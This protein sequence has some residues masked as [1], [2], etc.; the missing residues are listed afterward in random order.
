MPRTIIKKDISKKISF[1]LKYQTTY[2][3]SIWIYGNHPLLGGGEKNN[4]IPLVYL[5]ETYWVI[6]LEF[7]KSDNIEKIIYHYLIKDDQ[8]REIVE[9]GDDKTIDLVSISNDELVL[10]DTWNYAGQIENVFYTEPFTSTL[11]NEKVASASA[12]K[13]TK[14]KTHLFKVKAPLIKKGQSLCIIGESA[15]LGNWDTQ[16]TLPLTKIKETDYFE[17]ALDLKQTAFPLIYKYGIYDTKKKA[18]ISYELGNNRVLYEPA[19]KNKL[20][21]CND[22]FAALNN[23]QWKGAGVAIPVFSLRSNNSCG[24]GEF[25]DIKLL[26]DWSKKI[27]LK[28]IQLLPVNDTTATHSWMDSYPYAAISAFALHPL[29]I[30]IDEMILPKQ[31]NLI[32]SFLIEKEKLNALEVVDYEAVMKLKWKVL[33]TLFDKNGKHEL[34]ATSF[35]EFFNNNAHWLVPYSAFSYLRELHGTIDYNM[36][37]TH[38]KFD[39]KAIQK[40]VDPR[41]T[42]YTEIS[43]YYYVQFHLHLQLKSATSYAHENGIIVKGDIPIGVYR[44][45]AD[46]WQHP[47]LFHMDKQAGAPP[48]D[49]AVKGQNW[50]FPTY[51][52]KNMA[53]T[54]YSWWKLRFEQMRFYFDAFRIDHILGF[55]RIWSIPMHAVDGIMGRF[56]PAIPLNIQDFN[57]KGISWDVDRYTKPFINETILFQTFGYDNEYVKNNYFEYIGEDRYTFLP[58]FQTQVQVV[59]HFKNLPKDDWQEKIQN[60]LLNLLTNV[61]LLEDENQGL[62]HFRFNI[63]GTSSFQALEQRSKDIFRN[64]YF[65][66]FFFKQNETWEKEALQKLPNL[67][68]A[69]NMLICGEDLGLVPACLPE[70]MKQLGILSLEVQR[71]PKESNTLFFNPKDAPFLSVVTPSSHDTSTLRG[72]WEEDVAKTKQFFKEQLEQSGEAPKFCEPW[73]NKAILLQH[74]YSPAMWAIFQLQDY[75]GVDAKLRREDPHAERINEPSNP[76]HYWR[77]RMHLSLE[78]L[79][80]AKSFNEDW[81]MAIKESGR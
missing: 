11:L 78:T 70:V 38:S 28:L 20:V 56:V 46:T 3:Q 59:N 37:P 50:G 63:E 73:I 54:D 67:K 7:P 66:Y 35:T 57:S 52:W 18:F 77:Y 8:Q 62:Y 12:K 13:I 44:Y 42:T 43:F 32:E 6:H 58:A 29:F 45:G 81:A 26:V 5:N 60:G 40:L 15:I 34:T 33:R 64:L 72:W 36:W 9:W 47:T 16:K 75:L 19:S 61:I 79:M 23:T 4:A 17:I 21:I 80:A 1:H 49:F 27:G 2:G 74:L 76:K 68:R 53:A 30:R 69:T 31:K 24:V 10:I 25:S 41:S 48:D 71:M 55:F 51:H 14:T 39:E 22:G 65:D